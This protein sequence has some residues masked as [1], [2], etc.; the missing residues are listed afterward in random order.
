MARYQSSFKLILI[1]DLKESKIFMYHS[2]TYELK[3]L[4]R[5]HYYILFIC[6]IFCWCSFCFL[7][8]V[9]FLFCFVHYSFCLFQIDIASLLYSL[10]LT[11]VEAHSTHSIFI[12]MKIKICQ[13]ALQHYL[14][15]YFLE[16]DDHP[17]N[18]NSTTYLKGS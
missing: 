4:K 1:T 8:E 16:K 15:L 13:W 18:V 11:D 10:Y 9:L 6:L 5:V 3:I 14:F 2:H 7:K 17:S 12:Y